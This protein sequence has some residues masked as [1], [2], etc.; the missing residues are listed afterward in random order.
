MEI[1]RSTGDP[2]PAEPGFNIQ[3]VARLTGVPAETLRAW[4]RR[5]GVPSP[6][7]EANGQRVY[8]TRDVE[9]VRWLRHQTDHGL[10][11]KRAVEQLI[12]NP[13]VIRV[14]PL[15]SFDPQTLS[16]ELVAAA[17]RFDVNATEQVLSQALAAL[18]LEVYCLQFVQPALVDVGERWH[19]GEITPAVEHFCTTLIRRRLEQISSLLDSGSGRPLVVVGAAPEEQHDVGALVFSIL[20]RRRGIHVV[21][22][23]QR[24]P[25]Q[26][27]IDAAL[28]LKPDLI[29]LS[30]A[31]VETAAALAEVGRHVEALGP[32]APPFGFGGRAFT[33]HRYLVEATP[34]TYLG[35]GTLEA[36]A[37]AERIV[38][39]RSGG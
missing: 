15:A 28:R 31:A 17:L 2:A 7:R 10:T 9:T 33:E 5:Y 16:Q 19:R 13:D 20:L 39:A 32:E 3:A 22:L 11:A 18:P 4:E 8:T 27:V 24:L 6:R 26:A 37:Q 36:V 21:F 23:G 14:A 38:R 30:A 12:L 34:G 1:A 35:P 29:C 25:H